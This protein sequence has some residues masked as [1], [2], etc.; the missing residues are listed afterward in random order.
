[1]K[2]SNVIAALRDSYKQPEWAFFTEVT[3]G[4]GAAS[5]RRADAIAMNMWP[6]RAL[7]IR[8]FE[9]KVSRSDLKSELLDP[10]KAEAFAQ[11]TDS[12]YLAVPKGLTDGFDIPPNWGIIEVTEAGKTR[13][14]RQGIINKDATALT[15]EFVAGLLRAAA[16]SSESDLNAAIENRRAKLEADHYER[17]KSEVA[18][19]VNN[20]T[21]STA[22][23]RVL[24]DRLNAEFNQS[25]ASLAGDDGF[26]SAVAAV[27]KLGI[28]S[29][30]SGFGRIAKDLNMIQV[31]CKA[32]Q[33]HITQYTTDLS[34]VV[35]E[36]SKKDGELMEASHD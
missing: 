15:R 7:E 30:W 5:T 17:F 22:A 35:D 36:D 21:R 1:M 10:S 20:L 9:V 23:L 16:K 32:M 13:I 14:K 34:A 24:D 4:T 8:G 26:W 29:N 31:T 11:Y 33:D 12:F 27:H 3:D 2:S 19:E 6:S 25:A 28:S 18:R